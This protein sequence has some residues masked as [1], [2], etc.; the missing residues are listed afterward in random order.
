M[1]PAPT[2]TDPDR[3]K[4]EAARR[5]EEERLEYG[6]TVADALRLSKRAKSV[7]LWVRASRD[8]DATIV[9]I[10]PAAFRKGINSYS[11]YPVPCDFDPEQRLLSIGRWR[12]I[13]AAEQ[14]IADALPPKGGPTESDP[15]RPYCKPDQS[16]C[17][18]VCGN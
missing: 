17:D 2:I 11:K 8:G 5:A 14:R 3:A 13:Q 9:S 1:M 10:S 18:F 15:N 6:S 12:A 4:F 7:E 16:C